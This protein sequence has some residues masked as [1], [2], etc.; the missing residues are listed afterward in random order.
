M[1]LFASSLSDS[2]TGRMVSCLLSSSLLTTEYRTLLLEAS[3]N[4]SL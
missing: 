2:E 3:F 1:K 4:F